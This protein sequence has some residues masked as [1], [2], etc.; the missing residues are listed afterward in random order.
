MKGMIDKY[1]QL[2]IERASKMKIQ[3]CRWKTISEENQKYYMT[4]SDVCPMFGEPARVGFDPDTNW[5][6]I[7]LCDDNV[8]TFEQNG[9]EDKREVV[10]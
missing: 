7:N 5:T 10:K 3:Q 8:I 6:H 9:F 2:H 1:G 4:C